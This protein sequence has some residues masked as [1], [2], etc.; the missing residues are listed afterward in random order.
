M[1]VY[2][3]VDCR[4]VIKGYSSEIVVEDL[5]R[6]SNPEYQALERASINNAVALADKE[7]WQ[8]LS[9]WLEEQYL[10]IRLA[11]AWGIYIRLVNLKV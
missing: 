8:L 3:V 2:G 6:S 4:E 10:L 1:P 11:D 5:I 7:Y 9:R